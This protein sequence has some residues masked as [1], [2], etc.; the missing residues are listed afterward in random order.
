MVCTFST[1]KDIHP[2]DQWPSGELGRKKI[3]SI[4]HEAMRLN[5]EFRKSVGVDSREVYFEK[6]KKTERY[7]E[8]V[9][10]PALEETVRRLSAGKDMELIGE[11]YVLL[12]DMENSAD[13]YLSFAIGE[14]FAKNPRLIEETFSSLTAAEQQYMCGHIAWGMANY[15]W[16]K[17]QHP[18]QGERR[19]RLIRLG[20]TPVH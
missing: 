1:V 13:E 5:R 6:R 15:Y 2:N 18:E 8:D 12:I 16:N 7:D 14:V 9:L 17:F 3:A 10:T 4:F 19:D 11:L 20:C